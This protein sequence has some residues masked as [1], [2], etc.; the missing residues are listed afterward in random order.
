[1]RSPNTWWIPDQSF[2][3]NPYVAIGEVLTY[4]LVFDVPSGTL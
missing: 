3:N 2:T 1:M 4:E